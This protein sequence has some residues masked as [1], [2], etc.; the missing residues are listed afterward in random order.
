MALRR[1]DSLFMRLLLVQ[2]LLA[3]ALAVMVAALYFFERNRSLTLL[4]AEHWAGPLAAAAGASAAQ[5]TVQVQRRDDPPPDAVPL[6]ADAPRAR[7]LTRAL[8]ERGVAVDALR[9]SRDGGEPLV[10]LHVARAGGDAV[11][12]G[13]AGR[14]FEPDAPRR[15][16][17]GLA[18]TTLLIIALSWWTARR[19]TRPLERLRQHI[20]AGEPRA[21][22][23]ALPGTPPEIAEIESAYDELL[24]RL[25]R[26]ERERALL[27]AGVSHDLRS[28]LGRI[29]MAAELLPDEGA[30]ATRRA[31]IAANV[32]VA[33]RLVE[34]FL[35]LV[36]AGELPLNEAVD[37]AAVARDVASG[38]ERAHGELSVEAAQPVG[39]ARANR[40]LLERALANLVDNALKHGRPP[41]RLRVSAQADEA[42]VEVE[43]GGAG[44]AADA[45]APLLQAFARG[46]ASRAQ[47][48]TGLGLA[49]VRQVVERLGGRIEFDAAPQ[50]ACVRLRLPR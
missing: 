15:L 49:V 48:G 44:I 9:L 19:L 28:P 37:V 34:S 35:D 43:D 47:P 25:A 6:L 22:R 14:L 46:D 31:S 23:A 18:L 45:R 38:F 33:D 5:P 12:L 17:L 40:Q 13:V 21:S 7:I 20:R 29:R 41:V 27:L 1:W 11:W 36:R 30:S 39:L 2:T 32:Q 10:W 42:I 26:Q 8:A 3:L 16:V 4:L 24:A 50:P